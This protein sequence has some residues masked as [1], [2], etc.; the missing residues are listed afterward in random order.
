MCM[1]SPV[2]ERRTVCRS[3]TSSTTP[4][5]SRPA[6]TTTVS[7]TENQRSTNIVS[8]ARMSTRIRWAAK[9]ATMMRNDA[10]AIAVRRST[11]PISW[12]IESTIAAAKAA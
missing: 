6:W 12:P 1:T 9:A 4:W 3:D 8:P 7:P 2:T 10:P 5:S 11:P